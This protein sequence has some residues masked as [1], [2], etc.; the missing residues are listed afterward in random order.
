MG[1]IPLDRAI[2]LL[3]GLLVIAAVFVLYVW[4]I[5]WAYR[6]GKAR[7]KSGSLVALL[8]ALLHPWPLGLVLWY[9]FR[10]SHPYYARPHSHYPAE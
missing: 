10:P 6:D 4:T 3:L 1:G 8:V 5:F 9:V 7:G 2:A